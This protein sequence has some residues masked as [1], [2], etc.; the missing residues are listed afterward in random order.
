MEA[1]YSSVT[2]TLANGLLM[3]AG[4]VLTTLLV[5]ALFKTQLLKALD[6]SGLLLTNKPRM[7]GDEAQGHDK[8]VDAEG[9]DDN[10]DDDD[11]EEEGGDGLG[12][13]EEELSSEDGGDL[14]N[15]PNNNKS[16]S[17]KGPGGGAAAP[18]E[19]EEVRASIVAD[20]LLLLANGLVLWTDL[21]SQ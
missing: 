11:D 7:D 10:D 8:P 21:E 19:E 2:V 17:K 12:E 16:N 20:I 6:P 5:S 14:G 18:K 9:D 4:E 15:N 13:G 1:T 3:C